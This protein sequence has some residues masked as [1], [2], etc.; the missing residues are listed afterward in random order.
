MSILPNMMRRL[1]SRL[2][3]RPWRHYVGAAAFALAVVGLLLPS[4][5]VIQA[6]GPTQDVLGSMAGSPVISLK[7]ATQHEDDGHLLMVTVNASGVPGYPV[8]NAESLWA[9]AD[10]HLV[11]VPVEAVFPVGQ[12]ADEYQRQSDGQMSQSED[13]A[14]SVALEYA[15]N[16][17]V[18]VERVDAT[19][20]VDQIGGPSAGMMYT[21]GIID[22]L[23]ARDETNG[24][25]IAGTGT[26]DKEGKVGA[27]GGIRLKML[28]ARRDGATW[29][30]APA[31][32]CA[33]AVGYVPEGL[34]DVRVSTIDDA[35]KSLI[36][37]GQGK[38][39]SLPRCT[40]G[41]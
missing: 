24:L 6:P 27:I 32:N 25:T 20:K 22:K 3:S 29:F 11:V 23:T 16:L 12:T 7:G 21:L 36:A 34:R 13:A 38:G 1:G 5:Y 19:V 14:R 2:R 4:P 17:G 28:G 37:I 26:I 15:K 33:E 18:D 39:D 40:S 10:P 31:A 35:Y 30:L 8:I 9:W 41:Q